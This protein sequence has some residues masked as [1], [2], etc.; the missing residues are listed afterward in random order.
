MDGQPKAERRRL[1]LGG[2]AAGK[3][4]F[5]LRNRKHVRFSDHDRQRRRRALSTERSFEISSHSRAR[6]PTTIPAVPS[7]FPMG[8]RFSSTRTARCMRSARIRNDDSV[9]ETCGASPLA[10]AA[11][12]R[13]APGWFRQI[14]VH[15]A[16]L[17]LD[18][19]FSRRESRTACPPPANRTTYSPGRIRGSSGSTPTEPFAG[20]TR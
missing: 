19:Y 3:H 11:S 7:C 5:S 17:V 16:R 4:A 1:G 8:G 18:R 13:R 10:T 14:V 2:D 9:G 20:R 15:G 6:T 12:H